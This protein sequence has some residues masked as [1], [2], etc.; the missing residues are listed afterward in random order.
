MTRCETKECEDENVIA[1]IKTCDCI[2]SEGEPTEN[3]ANI[4][5]GSGKLL[6]DINSISG[7]SFTITVNHHDR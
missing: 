4:G 5:S 7:G 6:S 1:S 3:G 2:D